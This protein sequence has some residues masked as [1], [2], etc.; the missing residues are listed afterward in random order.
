MVFHFEEKMKIGLITSYYE[1]K[2]GGNEYYLAKTLSKL[3]HN[4]NIYVT[5]F[6]VPRYGKIKKTQEQSK[7]KNVNVIRLPSIGI[8]KKGLNYLFGLKKQLKN[9]NLDIIHVQEWFMPL[10]ISCLNF[11]NLILTQRINK[12][13]ISL[14]LFV[15]LFGKIILKN[16]KAITTLTSESKNELVSIGKI[17]N[18][19]IEVIPNGIDTSLF[20]PSMPLFKKER[21]T[22]LFVG[23]LSKEKGAE[24]L[25]KACS[26]LNFDYKL[27]ILGDGPEY[28][29]TIKLIKKEKVEKKTK[30]IKFIKHQLIPKIYCSADVL[31]V[32]SLAEPFGFVTL[33]A[34]ACNIPVIGTDIGG[35]KDIINDKVGIKVRPKNVDDL[36]K[37]IIR[38]KD[39]DFRKNLTKNC[40]NHII[41]NY[42]WGQITEM[43]LKI[44]GG[45]KK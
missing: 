31:V 22:I 36:T 24:Y 17:K 12:Y 41:Q 32:P 44:Y 6:T 30:V 29:K 38:I 13:P 43:Y 21:F 37:S 40:R 5:K 2:Y 1:E 27:I 39:D 18:K 42:S 4:V 34:L 11:K 16:A 15:K 45:I 10:T 9:D 35:M 23:R 19:E 7:L 3:S 20:K 33:E 14:K 28:K 26:R 8:R 25:I